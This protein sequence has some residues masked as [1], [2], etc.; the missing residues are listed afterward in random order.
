MEGEKPSLLHCTN[1]K[2]Q[3]DRLTETEKLSSDD[4]KKHLCYD[5]CQKEG[6]CFGCGVFADGSLAYHL[7]E[8]GSYCKECQKEIIEEDFRN[9]EAEFKNY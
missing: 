2:K 4:S 1:C 5:C 9:S 6:Y 8:V 7:S 3:A